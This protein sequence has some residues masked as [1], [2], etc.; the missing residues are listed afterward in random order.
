[1]NGAPAL[2]V[3]PAEWQIVSDILRKHIPDLEVRAF[4][5]RVKGPVKPYSDLD[6]AVSADRPLSGAVSAALGIVVQAAA[7]A[8]TR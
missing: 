2:H 7:A 6:L 1:M 3:S 4:G 5:S 8:K